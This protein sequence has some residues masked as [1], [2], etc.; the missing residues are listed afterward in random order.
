MTADCFGIL[1]SLPPWEE[2]AMSNFYFHC[3]AWE[4]EAGSV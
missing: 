3:P 2:E 4:A 1:F